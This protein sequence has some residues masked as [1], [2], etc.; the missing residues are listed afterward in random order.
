M[1]FVVALFC[2]SL[3]EVVWPFEVSLIWAGPLAWVDSP[4]VWVR[5]FLAGTPVSAWAG[6]LVDAWAGTPIS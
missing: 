2:C 3:S 6:T 5:A 1:V 4:T